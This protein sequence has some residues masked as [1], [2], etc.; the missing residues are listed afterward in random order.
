MQVGPYP[1]QDTVSHL[2]LSCKLAMLKLKPY[3]VQ[4]SWW[5][6][7]RDNVGRGISYLFQRSSYQYLNQ[8]SQNFT[9]IT[10]KLLAINNTR[11]GE[12]TDHR[13]M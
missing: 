2:L 5:C 4:L 11:N 10:V 1:T 9:E 13:V 7:A 8:D 3:D 6:L 12:A